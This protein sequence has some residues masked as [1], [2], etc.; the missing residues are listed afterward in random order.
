[1]KKY[2]LGVHPGHNAAAIIG[3]QHSGVEYAIQE[4]RLNGEKNYWG[5]P[6]KSIQACLDH[7]GIQANEV[8]QVVVG[9]QQ[10]FMRYHSREDVIA[11]YKRQDSLGGKVRQRFLMPMALK[12]MPKYG[13]KELLESLEKLGFMEGKI[14]FFDHHTS[15]AATA[16]FGLRKNIEEDYLVLTCDGSGD[17]LCASVRVMGPGGK[18]E[19]VATTQWN[20]SL[21]ALY[22]WTTYRMG[23]VPLEHEYKLMGM[24][25]YTQEK[26]AAEVRDIY[27]QFLGLDSSG[28]KFQRKTSKRVSDSSRDIFQ[29]LDGKRFDAICGGLQMFTEELLAE[30]AANAVKATGVRKVLAAGGVFMNVKANKIIAELP[31]VEYF[32]AFPSCGDETLPFGAYYQYVQQTA[33]D[34]A[35]KGLKHYY[36]GDAIPTDKAEAAI[37]EF[38]YTYEKPE[39]M[40]DRVAELLVS[41]QPVARASGGMEYGA[42]ALGNRSILADPSNQD[43]VRVINQMVKKRDFWMPFAPMMAKEHSHENIQNQKALDSPY[44]M[45]TFDSKENFKDMIAAVQ[46]ADLTCRAQL[47]T[48]EQNPEMYAIVDA[49]RQKTGRS[50]VLNTSFNL[51][52]FPI[53][54]TA[55]DALYI[56]K[57]S[58]LEYLIVGEFLVKKNR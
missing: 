10:N 35:V 2:I 58:G 17:D 42:R 27:R 26:Y 53:A 49:F 40:A 34:E 18:D 36:L 21:G 28:L 38:G 55:E 41:G 15:H 25:P 20:N 22:S 4:E 9:S 46:N 24:A 32:E 23:F 13:Q 56:L 19:V 7:A 48:Q 6:V 51:H 54:R 47:L 3:E 11:S 39:N 14:S 1:M 30:W 45:M 16:Y 12:L 57:N 33:G 37:K 31:E 5:F 8:A 29:R 44:M 52:G 43:V 50:V